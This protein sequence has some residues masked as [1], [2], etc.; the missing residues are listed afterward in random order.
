M[1]IHL[2]L[3]PH[4]KRG[5]QGHVGVENGSGREDPGDG[6]LRVLGR[7]KRVERL[8][9]VTDGH[10]QT[11]LPNGEVEDAVMA[12]ERGNDAGRSAGVAMDPYL[13]TP[14]GQQ[15]GNRAQG[16]ILP[17]EEAPFREITYQVGQA[18]RSI[19]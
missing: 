12:V 3:Q 19:S 6:L 10:D 11:P 13:E 15:V 9:D 17:L 16:E 18:R 14:A 4:I 5:Q 8:L 1:L 2:R 7:R